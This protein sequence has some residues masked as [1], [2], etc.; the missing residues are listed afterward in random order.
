MQAIF[1]PD[2]CAFGISLDE[3]KTIATKTGERSKNTNLLLTWPAPDDD[4]SFTITW[5]L[6]KGRH[7]QFG[8]AVPKFSRNSIVDPKGPFV[9]SSSAENEFG[10]FFDS[11]DGLIRQGFP[12]WDNMVI[13]KELKQLPPGGVKVDDTFS[14]RYHPVQGTLYARVNDGDEHLCFINIS[15]RIPLFPAVCFTDAGDSCTIVNNIPE[16]EPVLVVASTSDD[17]LTAAPTRSSVSVPSLKSIVSL[18]RG[19]GPLSSSR[20]SNTLRGERLQSLATAELAN[21]SSSESLGQAMSTV[22]AC[23]F[24]IRSFI[25]RNSTTTAALHAAKSSKLN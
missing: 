2:N 11:Y 14:L 12:S 16:S 7:V 20:R 10:F 5:C 6:K 25:R 13:R 24:C 8:L 19:N 4:G 17:T 15:D 21:G 9:T 3:H 22:R 1:D 18:K 23:V